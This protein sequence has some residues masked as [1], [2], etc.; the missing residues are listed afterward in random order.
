[1]KAI[2]FSLWGNHPKYLVGVLRNVNSAKIIYPDFICFVYIHQETV[3]KETIIELEK[4]DNVKIIY[5]TGDLLQNK[6]M[7]WR[8]ETI[9]Y[10]DV[11]I[12][13]S[14][15]VDTDILLRE[16]LAVNEWLRSD[17]ILHIMRDHPW[18]NHLI[19]GGMFGVKKTNLTWIDKINSWTQNGNYLYDQIFLKDIIYPLYKESLMI[20]ASFHKFEGTIC[21]DFAIK[22]EEDEYRFVGEYVYEDG[23]RNEKNIEELKAGLNIYI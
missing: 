18:H 6:P 22:F 5:K 21:K 17:C 16:K 3:P 13:I 11:E 7:M 20:H 14:R 23:S 19:Q 9:D 2:S 15:D 4:L 1:M 8:F 10:P 12:N